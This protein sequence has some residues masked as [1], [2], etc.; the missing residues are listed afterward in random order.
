MDNINS[1][2]NVKIAIINKVFSVNKLCVELI[3]T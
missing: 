2:T 3:L 1:V